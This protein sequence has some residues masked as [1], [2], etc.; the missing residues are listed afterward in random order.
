MTHIPADV[1]RCRGEDHE[2]KCQTCARRLQ[3]AAD[4]PGRWFP[5][6]PPEIRGGRCAYHMPAQQELS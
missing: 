6:M 2:A 1:S 3:L 4:A 5:M